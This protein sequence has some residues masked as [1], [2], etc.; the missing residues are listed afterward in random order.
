MA[1]EAPKMSE[2]G[3]PIEA[4]GEQLGFV[5]PCAHICGTLC[6]VYAVRPTVC[7]NYRCA[8]LADYDAG[9]IDRIE[10]NRRVA[11]AKNA[12]GRVRSCLL[13]HETMAQA[14]KR[15][16][17]D[18]R[19]AP[20]LAVALGMLD[21]QLDRFFRWPDQLQLRMNSPTDETRR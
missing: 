18:L 15:A 14:R 10:A 20:E 16:G 13:P 8:T 2:L 1:E 9:T 3:F 19:A 5:Q 4:F 21:L 6:Q 11:M 7:R 17:R 12:A